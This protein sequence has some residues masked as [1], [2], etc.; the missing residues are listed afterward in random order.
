MM[1]K[2]I[3]KIILF[4]LIST[5]YGCSNPQK[6]PVDNSSIPAIERHQKKLKSFY[7]NSK[8]T[9]LSK[10]EKRSFE[11]IH[12][13]PIDTTY[14][15]KAHFERLEN[16]EKFKM[17]TTGENEPLYMKFAKISF[18]LNDKYHELIVYQ[19]L[20]LLNEDGY[21]DYLFLPFLDE[22]NGEETYGGG[23]YLDLENPYSD[24]LVINFNLA[25]QPY[26]AYA[27]GYSCPIVPLENL[28]E[29]RVEAGVKF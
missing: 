26:C 25:Y 1:K 29:T 27:A 21:E 14:I 23:R 20:D 17:P 2:I 4:V 6:R 24:T 7:D 15:V 13:F 19:N 11:G 10:E 5:I 16:Q 18:E 9:P 8:T 12:F 28:V 22:T 3:S